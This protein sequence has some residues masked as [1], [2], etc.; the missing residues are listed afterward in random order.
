MRE[1][2]VSRHLT[3]EFVKRWLLANPQGTVISRDLTTIAI[4][5]LDSAWVTANYTPKESRTQQQHEILKLSAELTRDLLEADEYVMGVPMHNW[6]PSSSFKL[7]VDHIVTPFGP[8]LHNK[9]VT[10][11]VAAGRFY[12]PDSG[13]AS[14]NYVGPWLCT[15]FGGLGVEDMRFIF[16]DG[17]VEVRNGKRDLAAFLAPHIEAI[18]ELFEKE[19][20]P[21]EC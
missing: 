7:W 13:N 8:K 10:F 14:R 12:G 20:I 18:Q 21:V 15:L 9:R 19:R 6:G 16:A 17:A 2:S 4:P 11:V 1:A 3:K 5:V